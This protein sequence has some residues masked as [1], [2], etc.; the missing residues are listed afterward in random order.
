MV[1][2]LHRHFRK[3][4]Y[5]RPG[6][7]F[8]IQERYSFN[9]PPSSPY[10]LLFVRGSRNGTRSNIKL[11]L[12]KSKPSGPVPVVPIQNLKGYGYNKLPSSSNSS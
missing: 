8:Y 11:A 5:G 7:R 10:H 12:C 1:R 6:N 9:F 3:K 2:F 4:P